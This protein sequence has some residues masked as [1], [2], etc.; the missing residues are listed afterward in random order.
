MIYYLSLGTNQGNR[1]RNLKN[2]RSALR[3][4]GEVRTQSPVYETEPWGDADQAAFLNAVVVLESSLRPFRL[5]RKLKR[6]E[7]ELGRLR[8]RRWG[9]R[10]IDLD[11]LDWQGEPLSTSVLTIPHPL[12]EE[13]GF[14][15]RPLCDVDKEFK[16]PSGKTVFD[17]LRTGSFDKQV[18]RV[19]EN[20]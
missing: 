5:L 8:T 10:V 2:A 20:W 11:I 6:F 19:I 16:L 13:R 7:L 17:I 1:L 3:K 4:I 14:V 12:M 18:Q 9:P 15:L